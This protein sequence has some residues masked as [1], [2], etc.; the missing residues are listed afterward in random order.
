M[1][2]FPIDPGVGRSGDGRWSYNAYSSRKYTHFQHLK[3][4][5]FIIMRD[6]IICDQIFSEL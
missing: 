4:F 6:A 3:Y 2:S 5:A 1:M